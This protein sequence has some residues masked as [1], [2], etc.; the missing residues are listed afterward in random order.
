[1]QFITE[2]VDEEPA[3]EELAVEE[4]VDELPVL[5]PLLEEPCSGGWKTPVHPSER[6]RAVCNTRA[7]RMG[8]SSDLVVLL[9]TDAQPEKEASKISRMKVSHP[10]AQ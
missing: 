4:P 10:Y 1:V 9:S 5:L 7:I 6:S 3:V 8:S 2:P